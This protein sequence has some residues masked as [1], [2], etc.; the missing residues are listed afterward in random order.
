MKVR[1]QGNV[2][3]SRQE[4]PTGGDSHKVL[5]IIVKITPRFQLVML[6]F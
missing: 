6:K 4:N 5:I 3:R 2:V 1:K